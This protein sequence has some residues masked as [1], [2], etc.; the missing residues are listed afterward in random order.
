[1][2]MSHGF[3]DGIENASACLARETG[4]TRIPE[5]ASLHEIH[6]IKARTKDAHVLAQ[7]ADGLRRR[8]KDLSA[9]S[10]S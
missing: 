4:K 6:D 7:A 5:D 3:A 10:N 2:Q 1:M 8:M 9:H